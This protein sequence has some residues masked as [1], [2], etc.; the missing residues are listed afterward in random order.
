MGSC[1][2]FRPALNVAPLAGSVDRNPLPDTVEAERRRVA[3]LA[4]SV[5]RNASHLADLIDAGQVA[6]LAG[7][8]DRNS[9]TPSDED[10]DS[11]RSPRG[12]RG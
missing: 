11:R 2:K 10:G 5:D 6:P 12:E 3:P 4:G 7:S 9:Y 8:V 1:K